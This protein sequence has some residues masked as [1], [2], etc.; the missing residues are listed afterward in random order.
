MVVL[1]VASV[2]GVAYAPARQ[3]LRAVLADADGDTVQ[4][5]VPHRGVAPH[6][7]DALAR[8]LQ[9]G[10]RFV[11]GRVRREGGALLLEPTGIAT[12]ESFV[13][14]DLAGPEAA[15]RLETVGASRGEDALDVLLASVGHALA[16]VAHHGLMRQ[17]PSL[18]ARLSAVAARCHEAGLLHLGA[19][20]RTLGERLATEGA[21]G[22]WLDASI[23]RELAAGG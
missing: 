3:E 13:V 17:P 6:A 19:R 8:A 15:P 20:V 14:P 16:E 23:R 11:T 9:D 7:Q 10:T 2:L 4:L 12:D 1:A 18:A 5:V 22:A 21:A